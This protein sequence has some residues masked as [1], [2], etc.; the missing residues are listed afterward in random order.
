MNTGSFGS[1]TG[2][3]SPE[4][5]E[6]MSRR[7]GGNPS[8][9]MGQTTQSAPTNNPEIQI[10]T[11]SVPAPVAGSGSVGLPPTPPSAGT[12]I[13]VPTAES[14][15]IVKAL[16]SRLKSLSKLQGA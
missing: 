12:G 16:D 14:E 5:Q 9:T 15:L 7:A 1:A 10:P 13:G 6:A 11:N 8:G 4:L 2:G 3:I